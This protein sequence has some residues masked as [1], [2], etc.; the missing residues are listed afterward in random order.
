M[1]DLV[2]EV[3]KVDKKTHERNLT[4]AQQSILDGTSKWSAKIAITGKQFN[5]AV[6]I[7]YRAHM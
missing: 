3:F 2:G 1:F 5:E 6:G 7:P 4:Q